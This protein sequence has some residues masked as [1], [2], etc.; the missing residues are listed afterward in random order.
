MSRLLFGALSTAEL[1]ER[2]HNDGPQLTEGREALGSAE[3]LGYVHYRIIMFSKR[4]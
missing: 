2:T 1:D 4:L 3:G